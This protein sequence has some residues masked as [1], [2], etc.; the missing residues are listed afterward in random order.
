MQITRIPGGDAEDFAS[1]SDD[2]DVTW[3][4]VL[5][6]VQTEIGVKAGASG[7]PLKRTSKKRKPELQLAPLVENKSPLA[8]SNL[9]RRRKR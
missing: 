6:S 4:G 1:G 8:D 5:Q 7:S 3:E 2:D 9:K